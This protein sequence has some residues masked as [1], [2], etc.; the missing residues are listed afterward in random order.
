[1]V[2]CGVERRFL[3]RPPVP[4]PDEPRFVSIGRLDAQKGQH[5]L[6]EAVARVPGAELTLIGD[7]PLRASLESAA[8]V[9]GVADRVRFTGWL[10]ADQVVAEIERSRALVMASFAEGLPI[11]LMEALALGRPAVATDVAAVGELVETGVTG[12]LVP[13]SA[14]EPLADAIGEAVAA[15]PAELERM[16]RVGAERVRERHDA[17]KEARK[18]AALFKGGRE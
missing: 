3:D 13:A 12:W 2:R 6:I 9:L 17:A 5:L 10:G 4:V 11:V 15:P 18:L 16:G 14:L 7:G 1:V 8:R